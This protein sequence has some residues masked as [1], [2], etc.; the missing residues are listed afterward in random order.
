MKTCNGAVVNNTNFR[1]WQSHSACLSFELRGESQKKKTKKRSRRR[2]RSVEHT[3]TVMTSMDDS[4]LDTTSNP[5]FT[6]INDECA[7]W[8]QKC[9]EY[10]TKLT[11]AKQEFHDFCENSRELEAEL[12]TSLE[13]R[14]KTIRDLKHSLNQIQNDNESLRV[15]VD[16]MCEYR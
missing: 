4:V 11:D 5:T 9:S 6:N 3:H 2:S 15:S 14:E 7:Y 8:K 10:A 1:D 12:E 16:R 13:Q